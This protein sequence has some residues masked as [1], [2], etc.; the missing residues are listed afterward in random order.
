M[1]NES[2]IEP[3]FETLFASVPGLYM[4]LDPDLRIVAATEAYLHA[5]LTR[6]A[7]ILG[8]YVFDVFPD[9]P[10]DPSADAVR[11]STASF[12]RVL[13][14]HVTHVMGL[15]RHD[16]R[17]PEAEGGGWEARY[18]NAINSPVLKR[19]GSLAY[20]MHRVEN[21]TE[22]V[23]LQEQGVEQTK[24]T[25]V[26]RAQAVQMKAEIAERRRAEDALRESEAHY[27]TLSET[28]L[29]GVVYQDAEGKVLSMNPAA[30]TILGKTPDEFLGNTSVDVEH[31]AIRED[32]SPFPGL[33]HPSMVALATG[34]EVRTVRM[35]VY[36]PRAR[37]YRW[38]E[39][40]AVPLF[41]RGEANPYQVYTVF[42]D[43][44]ERKRAE[45][46]LCAR[47]NDLARAQA[48]AHLGSWKW[49]LLDDVVS[50]SDELYRIFGVDPKTFAPS[51]AAA[52]QL[53][54]PDDR[55]RHADAVAVALAG[56]AVG[57]FESRIIRSSG[58]E[59]VV[60]AS[61]FDVACNSSGKPI[62][63]F[64]TILDITERK[65]AEKALAT[66][67][68]EAVT[69]RNRLDAV[70]ESL[71]VGVALL[72]AQ[73]GSI[74]A[75]PAFERIWGSPRPTTSSESDYV[76]Y[77]AWWVSSGRQVQPDEWAS[78]VA[79][80]KGEVVVSQE[81][82]IQCFDG[83]RTFVLNGAAPIRDSNGQIVGSAVAI[84]D[85]TKRKLAEDALRRSEKTYRAI[86]ESIDYG[87]WVCAPDGSNTYASESYLKLVGM[88]Q[89]ECANFG[90]GNVLHPEDAERTI[91]AWNECVRT[92]G[93]WDIVH[94]FRGVD[95]EWHPVLA[96]GGPVRDEQGQVT[97]WAGIN[98]D[99]RAL[100]HTE[101]SLRESECRERARAVELEALMDAAP[102]AIFIARDAECLS[103]SGNRAAYALLRRQPD[104][105]LS[106]SAPD[107]P[108]NFRTMKDGVE[109]PPSE[110]PL[111][112]AASSGEPVRNYAMDVVFDDGVTLNLICDAVPLLDEEGRSRGAVG[113]LTDVTELKRAEERLRQA[114][115][116][117]SLGLLA[118]GVAHDFNNLLVG[119]IGNASLAQEI[120]PPDHPAADLLEGVLKTGEQA[121]HLTRQMLAYSG[122]GKFV[123]EPLDLSALIPE[124]SGLVRPSIPK[125][126]AFSL[127]LDSDLPAMEADRGQV[128]QVFMNLTLNASEAIGNYDG[129]ISVRTCVQEVD[130]RYLRLHPETAALR[131]GRY[132]C[133]EVSDTGCGM[134][135]AT[136]AKVFDPFFST[137][138]TG[139]GLGLA[140]VAGI[141]RGHKGAI[142]VD[143]APGKGS[144]FTVL[145]PAV[146]RAVKAPQVAGRDDALY[147]DGTVLV[148]DDEKVVREFAKKALER[149]GYTVLLADGGLAAIDAFKRHPGEIALVVLDLSMPNMSGEEALPELRKIR[150]EVKV[151]VSS[152][153]S[154]AE[155]M[156]LFKGQRVS[157]FVQK[158]YTSKGLAEKVK[159]C[160]G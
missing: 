18:W 138:F 46:L 8:R 58:E 92:E 65:Q 2:L 128:Q 69:E 107:G 19:D 98:L 81:L 159:V 67:L 157:G 23:L 44:S 119:V 32:G 158:P 147:G 83:R 118:G 21:V 79:V 47:E 117:E 88:T 62:L 112:K 160:L 50:W 1:S 13:Q 140:A 11:N 66:A 130:E 142:T 154:E 135:D 125:K 97:C 152:G 20:I 102:A 30:E 106:K 7:D 73:G 101:E 115:K 55:V 141:V 110:L 22:L 54:H 105:N 38:I 153:Y 85:I 116:L 120:L 131:P 15:Q 146:E 155:T 134:D 94:R 57:A 35:G 108:M 78:A 132:V 41:R 39:I 111:Q 12:R 29:Q 114:Q 61:G 9:N 121:A 6:R 96:R 17:K 156:T 3:D 150:S 26:L 126:I 43:I 40:N 33:E 148:V 136:K 76:N 100:K 59:R 133:L 70:M 122:K 84:M 145:F 14:S 68:A 49:D 93:R 56:K 10:G 5:T 28:M 36:N 74:R 4:V 64:G 139:R 51:N 27:R 42:E 109:I 113:V 37:Q 127:D 124:M 16:V 149:H 89:E 151:V 80:R 143:S 75:N 95:G 87:I 24:V 52:H 60:E 34:R 31:D 90:W 48:V 82:E 137:K 25:D 91:A 104:R 71:P 45:E 99:I 53:I 129:L 77:K 123:V 103:M 72:D 144:C 63:L 86:G